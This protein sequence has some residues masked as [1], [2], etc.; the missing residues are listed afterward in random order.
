[1]EAVQEISAGASSALEDYKDHCLQLQTQMLNDIK[2]MMECCSKK[3]NKII[4]LK[5]KQYDRKKMIK[6]LQQKV[7]DLEEK[8]DVLLT[9][10]QIAYEEYDPSQ[11][12]LLKEVLC[13]SQGVQTDP[14][15]ATEPR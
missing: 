12:L 6:D 4:R 1:M 10:K 5:E 8:S 3:D 13:L 14:P 9:T 7:A 2:K 15:Q 11:A